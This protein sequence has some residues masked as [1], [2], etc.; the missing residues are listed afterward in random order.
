MSVVNNNLLLT[1]DA[2][3]A[4]SA[5]QIQ[6]SLRF[7]SADSAYLNRTFGVSSQNQK[8]TFSCWVKRSNLGTEQ[9]I[10]RT[11]RGFDT[12]ID[13][14][15]TNTIRIYTGDGVSLGSWNWT[16][17]QV[18]QDSNAWFY[19]LAAWDTTQ[20]TANNRLQS[21]IN[22]SLITSYTTRE[23]ITQ[24][25]GLSFSSASVLLGKG[26]TNYCNGYLADV[27][28]IDGQALTPSS[29]TETNATTGQLVPKAYTGSYGTNGF[30]LNFSDNSAAT[31]ATLGADSS[32]NGNNWTPNNLS[33]S[34]GGPYPIATSTGALPVYNTTDAY[35]AVKG[36]GTRTDS[37]ASSLVLAIPMDGANNGT[38]FT[39]ESATIKGSGTAKAI[40]VVGN[41]K[42]LTAQ[43]K[44]YGSS[45]FFDGNGINVASATS[46]IVKPATRTR[47]RLGTDLSGN[48]FTGYLQDLRIYKGV[49][50]YTSNFTPPSATQN[51]TVA[52]GCDSLT[53][54]PTSYG[55]DTGAGGEVRGN[56]CTWNPLANNGGTLAN[57]NLDHTGTTALTTST[58][59]PSSGKW[60]CEFTCTAYGGGGAF[61]FT[62]VGVIQSSQTIN[63]IPT[64]IATVPAGLWIYRNDAFK[65]NNGTGISFGNTYG[66][67]D[68]IGVAF[69]VDFGKVWFA[70]N[71]TWQASGDP[72]NGTN[73][74]Y[75]N[76]TGSISL[77]IS[78]QGLYSSS[79]SF[80]AGQRPFAYAA[81]SGF[82]ALCDT[83]LP[84]PTIA[85]GSSVF[86]ATLYTGTGAALTPTSSLAFSPDL[87]W[88][89][90]RSIRH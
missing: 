14:L 50:K 42:T 51:T 49:A 66:A 17:T 22:G 33:V 32:G 59:F 3:V 57:G 10:L 84:T 82:K 55:T 41:T 19:F 21:Y 2:G 6:R 65:V 31:A 52:A 43:S 37:N 63:T 25:M 58:V 1:A 48:D 75:T 44:Y 35:G 8:A 38:T 36:T 88:I 70:K 73:A 81:P 90:G 60:Y 29:F 83:N 34:T 56:Y 71:G 18:F 4:P 7:N 9:G 87:V 62:A 86:D 15:S 39:D 20:V 16:T 54:T 23:T 45:G 12:I 78:D 53:D 80:N 27:H 26:L 40:T 79:Y 46:S 61:G 77:A 74:A 11:N 72:A 30:R 13:F 69:D 76:L 47:F 5:Y 28:F 24:N 89:K 64:S 85:K 68:V 67:T